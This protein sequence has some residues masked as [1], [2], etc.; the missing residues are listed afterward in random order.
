MVS[1]WL[2]TVPLTPCDANAV[3]NATEPPVP[4]VPL[5]TRSALSLYATDFVQPV[6]AEV[7]TNSIT[8]PEGIIAA[9]DHVV[10]LE[11]STLP[12]APGATNC[13]AD[14]P[15]PRST[16][17]AVS[18]AA[19]V[20]PFATGKV[21]VTLVAALTN[22]VDVEP[23]PPRL[24][25]RVPVVPASIGRPAQLVRVPELG[26][27]S[28]GVTS[29]GEVERTTAPVPVEVV[30]PV[31]PFATGKVPVTWVVRLTP[32]RV[33]PNVRLPVVVTVPVRVMPLT[34]P[35]P[36]TEVTVPVL[37]AIVIAPEP[38]V[39]VIPV[40]AVNVA[41]VKVLPVVLPINS[42]PLV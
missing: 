29:V 40:P 33:P 31:P 42:W 8:V 32:D 3:V 30:T 20:P 27:P 19:P 14:V 4:A 38:L 18:A 41:L 7:C 26:V 6:G 15:L 28:A 23:V 24:M 13:T 34:V 12:D 36:E 11:V 39:M 1:V 35:V 22:V 25:G 17:F 2:P 9:E 16:L 21:P 5:T 10:P 37:P